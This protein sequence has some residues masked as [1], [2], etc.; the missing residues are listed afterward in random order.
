[1]SPSPLRRLGASS[2]LPF[3]PALLAPLA[4]LIGAWIGGKALLPLLAILAIYPVLATLVLQGRVGT[5][6]IATLLWAVA[7][8][9]SVIGLTAHDPQYA[10]TLVING[11]AYRDEMFDFIRSGHGRESEPRLYLPQHSV[12][13]GAFILL[14][15]VSGGLL[16][17]AL[18]AVLV[19]YM[20]FYVG[21]LVAAGPEP[22]LAFA[23]GWPP[24]A[25]L[26]V[27]AYVMLGVALSR[28]ILSVV[29]RRPI[30]FAC[31]RAWYVTCLAL[32]V[33][34]ALL[35]GILAPLWSSLLR[36]CLG[37]P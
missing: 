7:L 24:W 13:L 1:V 36:P 9:I 27:V 6:T 2:A 17:I 12:H 20:S 8:S 35:K 15:V 31:G 16:G 11:D 3:V 34:D 19:N 25:I 18:G 30:G 4:V 37:A 32:L 33:L 23:L 21:A 5:A 14:A 22:W 10:G 29:T 26:R 28:P